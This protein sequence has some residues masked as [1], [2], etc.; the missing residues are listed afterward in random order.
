MSQRRTF[1][2]HPLY[3]APDITDITSHILVGCVLLDSDHQAIDCEMRVLPVGAD[4]LD[5]IDRDIVNDVISEFERHR[6]AQT[7]QEFWHTNARSFSLTI[8]L[9]DPVP[10]AEETAA[11]A[12]Q[13]MIHH[14]GSSERV[15]PKSTPV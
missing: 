14:V 6:S 4:D 9:G 8:T 2:L 12:R 3:Y 11:E 13:A 7:L 1:T 15:L 5:R 10:L